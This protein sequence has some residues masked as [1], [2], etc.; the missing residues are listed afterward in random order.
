MERTMKKLL[1]TAALVTLIAAP[2]LAQNPRHP[3]ANRAS[4]AAQA[5]QT[6]PFGRSEGRTHSTNASHDVYDASGKYVGSDPDVRIRHDLLRDEG[7][8]D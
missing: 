6:A 3:V 1:A 5:S 2:A 7:S 4:A 8:T